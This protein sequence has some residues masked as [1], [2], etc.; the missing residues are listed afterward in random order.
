MATEEV[1]RKESPSARETR[2]LQFWKAHDIFHKSEAQRRGRSDYVFYEGPPTA[3]GLPHPGHVLTRVYKDVYL[4]YKTMKGF[5][6]VRKGGWDTHGLPVEI[7]IEKKY[8]LNGK[9]QIEEFGIEKFVRACRDSVFTYEEKWRELT[10]RLGY[11]V[12]LDHPYMTMDD[13]Y[14]ESVWNLLKRIF[15]KGL[16]VQGHRVSPYCPHCETTLSSHEVA[17]GYATVK[18]LSVTAKFRVPDIDGLCTYLLAWTTTPWTLPSNVALAVNPQLDYVLVRRNQ[19]AEN[20]WIA[21]AL[22]ES[23]LEKDSYVVDRKRGSDLV[24]MKYEPVFPFATQPG[25]KHVIIASSHVT[26]DSGTGIVH[27]APAHGEDDYRVCSDAGILFV[28]FVDAGGRFTPDVGDYHGR[29]VKDDQLNVDL[30]RSLGE[31]GLVFNKS[32]HEHAYPHCWRCDTPLIYYAVDS[33]FVQMSA[34]KDQLMTNSNA[35]NWIPD[36]I[37]DG[38]MGNFLEN[39]LDWN[40]SRSRY[41]GTPLPIWRCNRC[42]GIECIG[43][44]NELQDRAGR[45]PLELHKPYI[46][47]MEWPCTCGDGTMQR[48]PEVIDVWFDSGSMPFAQLHYPFENVD[49][50]ERLYPADFICEAIDQTRGWFYSLLAI[51]T[52]VTK[53]APYKNALVLGHV[54]DEQGKKMSKSKGNVI[55]PFDAF[56]Q[57]GADALRYYF[58]V[59]TQPWNNQLFYFKAVA[60]SKSKF[61]DLLQNVFHFYRMYADIDEFKPDAKWIPV[62]ERPVFDR[63]LI[64]RLNQTITLVDARMSDYD[65]T[66]AARAL[67][68]F[69]DELSTWY[70]RRNRERFWASGVGNDKTAAFLTLHEVLQTVALLASPLTPFLA[71]EIYQDLRERCSNDT[72]ESVHLCDFP[73]ADVN[74]IDSVLIGEMSEVELIV[75]VGRRLRNES[76]IKTRQPLAKLYLSVQDMPWLRRFCDIIQDELNVK[77]I[78]FTTVD[79]ISTFNL[80]LKLDVVGREFGRKTNALMGA[81]T[82]VNQDAIRAFLDKGSISVE[83]VE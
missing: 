51:S 53:Q 73:V 55:D 4:R 65:A 57:F 70:I 12:D 56:D 81:V 10:E 52:I 80:R 76:H 69:V 1:G 3:N 62:S 60:Q 75:E 11:W 78:E 18:D 6:I 27:M 16:L 38:R 72:P 83:S 41:W 24:G 14:I 59:N 49:A 29:F 43:S 26:A 40:L 50:F 46:D 48:V 44:K 25:M 68:S 74:I 33:W 7:E 61:L 45:L 5:H 21:E 32:K 71:E 28:N 63:W 64:S 31:R 8:G 17:Q 42:G 23:L 15:D 30:V 36:H 67:Q 54:L 79:A 34:V 47:G 2:V 77:A 39:I 35:V 22:K 82:L 13:N 58:I 19:P 20:V 37:R 66:A 9:K